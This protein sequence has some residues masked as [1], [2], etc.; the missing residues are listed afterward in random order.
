MADGRDL[1][2]SVDA[3]AA[4]KDIFDFFGLPREL[5][6]QVYSL[7]AQDLCLCSDADD[8]ED[9][10]TAIE[11]RVAAAPLPKLFTLCRQ[12]KTEYEELFKRGLTATFKDLG[13]DIWTTDILASAKSITPRLDRVTKAEIHLLTICQSN[14]CKNNQCGTCFDLS[15]HI[16]WIRAVVPEV[17]KLKE[18]EVKIYKCQLGHP[19]DASSHS[20]RLE[21]TLDKVTAFPLTCRIEVFPFYVSPEDSGAV[22]GVK[23]YEE[24]QAPE[25]VWTKDLGWRKE[26]NGN[27][28]VS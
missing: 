15:S 3:D 20:P 17:P 11:V 18:I 12:F 19:A 28:V 27:G 8:D 13:R 16:D 5:R 2:P 22:H 9:Y 7:L 25:M 1:R 10:S 14:D 26:N 23:A 21:E 4:K 24:Q 6:N